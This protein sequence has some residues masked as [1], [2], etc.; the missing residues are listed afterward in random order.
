[1][2]VFVLRPAARWNSSKMP[3][4]RSPNSVFTRG[5]R[6]VAMVLSLAMVWSGAQAADPDKDEAARFLQDLS[7][8]AEVMLANQNLTSDQ[9]LAH[10]EELIGTGFDID[11]MSRFI[12]ADHWNSATAGEREEFR[13]LFH[14]Y[15]LLTIG[16]HM[17]SIPRFKLEVVAARRL[18]KNSLAVRS[19][20]EFGDKR[21][22]L[23]ID[24]RLRRTAGNWRIADIVVQG[25]SFAAVIRSEFVAVVDSHGGEVESLLAELR[26]KATRNL[27]ASASK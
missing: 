8:R 2:D 9:R 26:K 17:D 5:L 7:A 25:I 20:L 18:G 21:S 23:F 4:G 11:A 13:D 14:D 24:W 16:R 6:V 19:N 3:I 12:L 15:M 1:M 10:V 27:A 22:T